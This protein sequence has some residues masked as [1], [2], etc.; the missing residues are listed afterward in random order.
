MIRQ[1][2][3]FEVAMGHTAQEDANKSYAEAVSK[4]AGILNTPGYQPESNHAVQADL[5]KVIQTRIDRV[6]NDAAVLVKEERDVRED[7]RQ[8]KTLVASAAR[9]IQAN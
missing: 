1:D 8:G 4:L 9:L 6:I 3:D 7:L 2:L 5:Q